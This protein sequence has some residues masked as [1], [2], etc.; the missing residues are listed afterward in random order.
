MIDLEKQ[1]QYWRE[2]AR[3]DWQVS[4]ELYLGNR[5]RH[6]L[7][8]AQLALEKMLKAHVVHQTRDIPPRLHSLVRL[9]GLSN[10]D[11]GQ[12]RIDFLAEM[13]SFNIEGRYPELGFPVIT[14]EEAQK[15]IKGCEDMLVW[16]TNQL[17]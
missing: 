3:E 12:S 11:F 16:L 17:P 15:Y 13:S 4:Q 1:I 5:L 14:R 8:F 2:S 7:F 6:A 9:A 10:L